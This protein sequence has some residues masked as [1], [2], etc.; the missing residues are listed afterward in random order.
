MSVPPRASPAP[1]DS[2]PSDCD[3]D[4]ACGRGPIACRRTVA[5]HRNEHEPNHR[6][7]DEAA[8]QHLRPIC[9]RVIALASGLGA[10]VEVSPKKTGVSLRRRKQ[11]ALIEVPSATRVRLGFNNKALDP[12][13]RLKPATGMC[14][15]T[16]DLTA[17]DDIDS[18]I[19]QWLRAAYES[20]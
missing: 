15:H 2:A 14:T 16:V 4:L 3:P 20:A 7:V 6:R 9:D 12:T 17:L 10:D 19:L 8:K 11:F 13:E 5:Q 18:E 1:P